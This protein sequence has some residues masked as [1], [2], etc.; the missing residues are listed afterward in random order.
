MRI[1]GRERRNGLSTADGR[2]RGV[3]QDGEW[4]RPIP[5]RVRTRVVDEDVPRPGSALVAKI[6]T[7][8]ELVRR[9]GRVDTHGIEHVE[10]LSSIAELLPHLQ[11]ARPRD[12]CEESAGLGVERVGDV[13]VDAVRL[14]IERVLLLEAV[15]VIDIGWKQAPL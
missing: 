3:P 9:K 7:R 1:D 13:E 15:D 14:E 12:L 5:V 8:C 10:P 6:E 11:L 4:S 2:E